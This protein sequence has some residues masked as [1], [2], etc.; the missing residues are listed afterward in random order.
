MHKETQKA[1][2]KIPKEL[3]KLSRIIAVIGETLFDKKIEKLRVDE[4][5]FL[6]LMEKEHSRRGIT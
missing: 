3:N 5:K 6:E 1:I 2:T 4:K